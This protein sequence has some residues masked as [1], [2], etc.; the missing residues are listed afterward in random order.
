M[1]LT[2]EIDV[3]VFSFMFRPLYPRGKS[4]Q[5]PFDRD[6]GGP[7]SRSKRGGGTVSYPMGSRG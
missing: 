6:L 3:G 1:F 4:P 7:Q 5:Y 2:S